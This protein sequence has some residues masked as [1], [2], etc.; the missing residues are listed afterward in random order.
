MVLRL[1]T[2]IPLHVYEQ[3]DDQP[4]FETWPDG[5]RPV[6]TFFTADEAKLAVDAVNGISKVR[7]L[8]ISLARTIGDLND[9]E[10]PGLFILQGQ[11]E[12][13]QAALSSMGQPRVVLDD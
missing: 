5:D 9:D 1:G 4:N 8:I 11:V 3:L 6:A 2:H 12:G 13:L 7:K 10:Q